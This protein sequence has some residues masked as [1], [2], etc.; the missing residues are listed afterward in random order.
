[1]GGGGGGGGSGGLLCGCILLSD[2]KRVKTSSRIQFRLLNVTQLR[3]L[4]R[5][6]HF[7][8][9]PLNKIPAAVIYSKQ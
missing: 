3:M 9:S 2:R 6:M 1:M 7:K 5:I 4:F 8:K